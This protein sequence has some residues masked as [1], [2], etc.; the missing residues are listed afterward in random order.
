M[1]LVSLIMLPIL[2]IV[3]SIAVLRARALAVEER[4]A[5][6]SVLELGTMRLPAMER[7]RLERERVPNLD[8][9]PTTLG[10]R[11]P[12]SLVR[13]RGAGQWMFSFSG[14]G[15]WL[16]CECDSSVDPG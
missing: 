11:S 4:S 2:C 6:E 7:R 9:D 8:S 16:D 15:G 5:I 13:L 1:S 12:E 3:G 14:K 10:G